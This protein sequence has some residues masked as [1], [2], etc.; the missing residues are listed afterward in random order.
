M[1]HPLLDYEVHRPREF[2]KKVGVTKPT[3]MS[4][5][6][7]GQVEAYKIGSRYYIPESELATIIQRAKV[8]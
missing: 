1:R 2:A 5:I 7:S 4:W 6:K 8:A 3:I